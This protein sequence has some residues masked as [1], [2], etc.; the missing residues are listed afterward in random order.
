[1]ADLCSA[2]SAPGTDFLMNHSQ[3]VTPQLL[4]PGRVEHRVIE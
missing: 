2:E 4:A 3:A 1:V